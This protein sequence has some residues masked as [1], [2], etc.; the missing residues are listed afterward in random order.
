MTE[1]TVFTAITGGYDT[2]RPPQAPMP[3]VRYV[4]FSDQPIDIATWEIVLVDITQPTPA[5]MAR[6]IKIMAHE[7]LPDAELSMWVDGCTLLLP[8][9]DPLQI[10]TDHLGV[11]DIAA[12]RHGERN[13]VYQEAETCLLLEKGDPYTIIQQMALYHRKQYPHRNGMVETNVLLRRHT[14]TTKRFNEAWWAMMQ[15]FSHRD[16]LSFNYVATAEDI[17]Y[18]EITENPRMGTCLWAKWLPH[19]V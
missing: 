18:A 5:R 15:Q 2:L 13:C 10:C 14:E 9:H 7:Y 19:N 3:N 11:Y 6:H 16:Q 1:V 17:M 12:I 4:C 8:G